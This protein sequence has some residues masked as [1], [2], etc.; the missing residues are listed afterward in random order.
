VDIIHPK[1]IQEKNI[2]ITSTNYQEELRTWANGRVAMHRSLMKTINT[3]TLHSRVKSS[4]NPNIEYRILKENNGKL[5]CNCPGFLYR[6]KC[7]HINE[8]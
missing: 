8:L 4:S 5:S 3:P 7:R 6:R 2:M 1:S